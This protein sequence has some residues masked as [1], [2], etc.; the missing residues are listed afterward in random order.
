MTD[1]LTRINKLRGAAII[2]GNSPSFWAHTANSI[3]SVKQP[4]TAAAV[5]AKSL[6]LCPTLCNQMDCSPPGSS[7]LG[8]LQA[9]MLEWGCHALLQE[10]FPTQGSN[11]HLLCLLHWQAGSLPLAPPGK[12]E[13]PPAAAVA[14]SLQSCSTLSDPMDCS[15]PGSSVHGIFQAR[16][17]EWGAIA[18]SEQPPNHP[19]KVSLL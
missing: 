12:P 17:L 3:T 13:Q 15:L 9:R 10:I 7:V 18:F 8:I 16:V 2:Q 1:S 5:A 11:P 6:R 19:P 14:K 4:P